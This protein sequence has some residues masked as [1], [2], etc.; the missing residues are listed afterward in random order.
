MKTQII[1]SE[2]DFNALIEFKD[3]YEKSYFVIKDEF[4]TQYIYFPSM[5][6]ISEPDL[7]IK[8]GGEITAL[9]KKI[10]VLEKK[11]W[12]QRIF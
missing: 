3:A 11:R 4:H 12:W 9:K 6:K 2:E 5:N 8:L 7:I 1:L 10:E